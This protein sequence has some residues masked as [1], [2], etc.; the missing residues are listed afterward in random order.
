M[1]LT[2]DI[3]DDEEVNTLT[4]VRTTMEVIKTQYGQEDVGTQIRINPEI[5]QIRSCE[6]HVGRC[7]EKYCNRR[8]ISSRKES[9]KRNECDN[10]YGKG[11]I[12]SYKMSRSK[13]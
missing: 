3:R 11:T 2:S 12:Y 9:N 5:A 1:K 7:H 6:T 4:R 13:R 8:C 10:G